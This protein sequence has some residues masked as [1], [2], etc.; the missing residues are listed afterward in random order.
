M[1]PKGRSDHEI[2][3]PVSKEISASTVVFIRPT[4]GY[5]HR[6]LHAPGPALV[7]DPDN[8]VPKEVV[9]GFVMST[10]FT[11]DRQLFRYK[12]SML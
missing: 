6:S 4:L 2:V 9:D 7:M 11:L 8:L 12:I 5:E 3:R 10:L 1:F